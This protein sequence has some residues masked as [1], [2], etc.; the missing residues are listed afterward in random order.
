MK[1]VLLHIFIKLVFNDFYST[2]KPGYSKLEGTFKNGL[3]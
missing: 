1:G 3:L 2:V